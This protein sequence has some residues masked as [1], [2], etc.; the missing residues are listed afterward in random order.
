MRR[1]GFLALTGRKSAT[2]A[3]VVTSLLAGT[4]PVLAQDTGTILGRVVS[5]TNQP[6]IGVPVFLVGTS[7]GTLSGAN[8]RYSLVNVPAGNYRLRVERIGT[9]TIE[10]AITVQAGQSLTQDFTLREEALGLDQI[11]VTG[12]AG[13]AR[14]REVGNSVTQ[15]NL[16]NVQ[17]PPLN[18]SSLLQGRS[19]GMTVMAGSGMAGSGSMIRL[20]GNTSVTMTN[21]PLVYIDGIRVR[22][23]G[24]ALNV[25][26]SG[27]NL[28]G[29]NDISSPLNDINPADIERIEVIKGAAAATLYG[30]EAAAGVIQVFTKRGHS[31]KPQWTLQV[32]QGFART[33]KFGPDPSRA[34]P[35]DTIPQI[36]RDSFPDRFA[37]LP[38]RG[39][40][41]AGG[42]SS[43]LF[44]DP[45]L[46]N[47][48][49]QR[50]SLSVGGGGES[51]RYFVSGQM[52]DEDAVLPNDNEKRKVIRGNF[53]FSPLATLLF[54]WNTSYTKDQISNT[55][56]GNNAHGMTLNAF[57]RDRNYVSNDRPEVMEPLLNQEITS[58]IDHLI[59]GGTVSWS[60]HEHDAQVDGRLRPGAD[61][62]P[63]PPAVRVRV[64]TDRHHLRP[65]VLVSDAHVRLRGQLQLQPHERCAH[66]RLLGRS[67][68]DHG[69]A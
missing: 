29:G 37:G 54:S 52:T 2:L 46:R 66:D 69:Y 17:E 5:E 47:A 68:C 30:T 19:P 36:Y 32:D 38:D 61:R 3:L 28:R 14:R 18:L 44:I 4:Q 16:A 67:E 64:G 42:T 25:P 39:V 12:T 55:A 35:S 48:Y 11:V 10:V 51:L 65:Q 27:S 43:Y 20:R 31:G 6:L 45:W 26:P 13:A 7:L 40:S 15:I 22:S 62:Q 59:S 49:Q 21:Q 50:Y 23:R 33:L 24:Y 56:A 60:P 1:L 8:G 34:P 41:R 57:R 58:E 53:S 9:R 63:Q